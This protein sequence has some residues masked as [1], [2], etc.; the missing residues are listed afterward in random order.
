MLDLVTAFPSAQSLYEVLIAVRTAGNKNKGANRAELIRPVL[1]AI[2]GISCDWNVTQ[3]AACFKKLL[4]V[5][6]KESDKLELLLA[7]SGFVEKYATLPNATKRRIAYEKDR[8]NGVDERGFKALEKEENDVLRKMA[9]EILED[10]RR[11]NYKLVAILVSSLAQ[12]EI[13][14]LGLDGFL[15]ATN[16]NDSR[17]NELKRLGKVYNI[18]P[19][20]NSSFSGRTNALNALREGFNTGR[21]VQVIGASRV[22]GKS[23]LALEYARQHIDEYQIVCWLNAWNEECILSSIIRFFAVAGIEMDSL[24]ANQIQELFLNFFKV[25]AE[26]WLII[27]DNANMAVSA[28]KDM[29]E[30]Y[31][32]SNSQGHI[33]ITANIFK[34]LKGYN[35]H[36]LDDLLERNEGSSLMKKLMGKPSLDEETT[37]LATLFNKDT[38]FL[39][40]VAAYIRQ[41]H[42]IDMAT[43]LRL[44][45]NYGCYLNDPQSGPFTFGAF[46]LLAQTIFAKK[47]LSN[48]PIYEAVEQILI[49]APLF[50][51]CNMD[52]QFFSNEF[53]ILPTSLKEIYIHSER[54]ERLLLLLNAFC[55]Y[56]VD[57]GLLQFNSLGYGMSSSHFDK[58]TSNKLC[59]TILELMNN[60]VQELQ[61]GDNNEVIF[62]KAK[63]YIDRICT[64]ASMMVNPKELQEKYP[65]VWNLSY[66]REWQ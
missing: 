25:N 34:A 5:Y 19:K 15:S 59:L 55:I 38:Y 28:Q 3:C 9:A 4:Q 44:L 49:T 16:E 62:M 8:C 31:M 1:N 54:R 60:A 32:P 18:N 43:Y 56:E 36:L 57:D 26:K 64:V 52:L 13:Y 45:S 37:T 61:G 35:F 47:K 50:G 10:Y 7:I 66:C 58:L 11:D 27:Y 21:N 42:Q 2:V 40:L 17:L 39:T 24:S 41:S 65:D 23:F 12:Q 14:S 48:D 20:S 29:L 6:I 30:S 33:L 63:P 51:F 22:Q 46:E 53:P